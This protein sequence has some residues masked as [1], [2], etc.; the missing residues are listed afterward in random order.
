M[1]FYDIDPVPELSRTVQIPISHFAAYEATLGR[2][3]RQEVF[4]KSMRYVGKEIRLLLEAETLKRKIFWRKKFA[5]GWRSVLG[6]QSSSVRVYNKAYYARVIEYGRRAGARRP[7]VDALV[8]WV[9]DRFGLRGAAARGM[10]FVIARKI[11]ERGIK[12][13]FVVRD[14]A[15]QA[16]VREVTAKVVKARL[17]LAIARVR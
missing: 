9:R 5:R 17:Q 2:A 3:M 12:P 16:E 11:G 10:A 1:P 6:N 4:S 14:P 8:P 15:V 7:P 13:R